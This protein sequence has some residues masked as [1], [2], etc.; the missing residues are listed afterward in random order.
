VHCHNTG[1]R[2]KER[3]RKKEKG[4]RRKE[5]KE[6]RKEKGERTKGEGREKG[7]RTKEGRKEKGDMPGGIQFSS[8]DERSFLPL[9]LPYNIKQTRLEEGKSNRVTG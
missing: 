9:V 8:V 4:E 5:K 7:E 3:R 1:E 6:R 2:R